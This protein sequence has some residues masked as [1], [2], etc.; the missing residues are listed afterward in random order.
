MF[1]SKE[2]RAVSQATQCA[3]PSVSLPPMRSLHILLYIF[4]NLS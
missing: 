1:S 3:P 4:C 2:V